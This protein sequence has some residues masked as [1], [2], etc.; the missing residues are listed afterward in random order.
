MLILSR[1]KNSPKIKK[2][3]KGKSEALLFLDNV[4]PL[5]VYFLLIHERKPLSLLFFLRHL[6]TAIE[7]KPLFLRL[8]SAVVSNFV[9][10]LKKIMCL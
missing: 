7:K 8:D 5:N 10:A 3:Y 2:N 9:E 1:E 6:V 4:I